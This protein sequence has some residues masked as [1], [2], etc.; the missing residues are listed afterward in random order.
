MHDLHLANKILNLV[1]E[2]AKE[3]NL[4]KISKIKIE[5]GEITEHGQ[6][7]RP[8]NLKFNLKLLAKGTIAE[9]VK[10]KI[11]P[12]KKDSFILKEIIGE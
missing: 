1:L 12:I 2:K 6:Q 8:E 7:I 3:N 4:K 10:V 11:H 5:L 9:G